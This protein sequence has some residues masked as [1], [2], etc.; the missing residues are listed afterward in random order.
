MRNKKEY[1]QELIATGKESGSGFKGFDQSNAFFATSAPIGS[2]E[3]NTTKQERVD[4]FS[5]QQLRHGWTGYK[6]G[7]LFVVVDHKPESVMSPGY[8]YSKGRLLP[9]WEQVLSCDMCGTHGDEETEVSTWGNPY[10]HGTICDDCQET[11]NDS[12]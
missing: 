1:R 10:D 5:A 4:F 6:L 9:V 11:V 12:R 3:F 2:N 8:E 7:K